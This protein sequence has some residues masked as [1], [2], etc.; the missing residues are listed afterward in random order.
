MGGQPSHRTL[1]FSATFEAGYAALEV[2]EDLRAPLSGLFWGIST[3]AEAFDFIGGI[4]QAKTDMAVSEQG[5]I[6]PRIWILFTIL[7]DE[8][9]EL[10]HIE[11]QTIE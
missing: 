3:R 10:L 7:D 11:A 6:I 5:A 2:R 8:R 9:V 4:G 1:I